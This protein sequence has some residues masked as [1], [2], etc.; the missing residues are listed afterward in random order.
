[1]VLPEIIRVTFVL[2]FVFLI[3]TR[4]GQFGVGVWVLKYGGSNNGNYDEVE[5]DI[6]VKRG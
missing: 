6:D 4:M 2:T 1:M 3:R 5:D